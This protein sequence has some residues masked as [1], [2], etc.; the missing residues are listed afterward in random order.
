MAIMTVL[1]AR[2]GKYVSVLCNIDFVYCCGGGGG[3]RV[4]NGD[5][6]TISTCK[7]PLVKIPI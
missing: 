5:H 2:Q 7:G 6:R 3:G 1:S 4:I